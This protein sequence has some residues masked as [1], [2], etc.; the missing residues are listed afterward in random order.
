MIQLDPGHAEAYFYLGLSYQGLDNYPKAREALLKAIQLNPSHLEA[1]KVLGVIYALS[2]QSDKAR[3]IWVK[4]LKQDPLN[5][6]ALLNLE[7]LSRNEP[8]LKK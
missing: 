5:R 6:P 8:I 3:N 4:I 7:T 2:G 1:Y